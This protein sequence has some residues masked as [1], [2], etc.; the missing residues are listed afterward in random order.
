MVPRALREAGCFS[1]IADVIAPAAA[2]ITT[3][4]NA[5][6]GWHGND[7]GS[8]ASPVNWR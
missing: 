5:F 8:R 6:H 7:R 3:Q 4:E 1:S 2:S